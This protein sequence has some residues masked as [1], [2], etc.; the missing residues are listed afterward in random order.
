LI[1]GNLNLVVG[2]L[3]VCLQYLLVYYVIAGELL[4][5]SFLAEIT[6]SAVQQLLRQS[7][8]T[9]QRPPIVASS[10]VS[11][12]GHQTSPSLS[13]PSPPLE[14]V[15]CSSLLSGTPTRP[16]HI[17]SISPIT[18]NLQLGSGIR[19][20]APHLQP[21]RPSA[22]IST[23]GLSSFLHGMQSQ[24]VPST[25]PTL[26]EIPSRAPASVQQSGP[27]TTTNCCESMGVSPSSTYLSG[28]DSLMDGGYQTS[29]NA[30]QPCSFPP[31]TNLISNPNQLTQPEL[32]MLHSVNSVLTNPASEVCLSDDD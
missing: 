17:G 3:N 7:Q 20:P 8:P 11:A 25:S 30:T 28:L 32:S 2:C 5:L 1:D 29:T 21:F 24:Q 10:G 16:P 27:Q 12:D 15:R 13:P 19:A 4:T 31:V 6:S 23:T 26:S 22:S 9:A 18:N 14:V